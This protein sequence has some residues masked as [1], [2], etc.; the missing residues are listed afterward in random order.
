[1]P[2]QIQ[3]TKPTPFHVV[4][5]NGKRRQGEGVRERR[6]KR[7]RAEKVCLLFGM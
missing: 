2:I 4:R 3:H 5:F 6:E 1:M 7:R